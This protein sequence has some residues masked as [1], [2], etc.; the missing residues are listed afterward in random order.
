MRH[1]HTVT[2]GLVKQ[3]EGE[4]APN[5]QDSLAVPPL[6]STLQMTKKESSLKSKGSSDNKK[7]SLQVKFSQ[8][9]EEIALLAKSAKNI[10]NSDE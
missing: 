8:S 6:I 7:K 5:V 10:E 1:A 9:E 2:V 3:E 4:I